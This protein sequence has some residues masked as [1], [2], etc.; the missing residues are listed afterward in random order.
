MVDHLLQLGGKLLTG[1]VS[2]QQ[3]KVQQLQTSQ[4]PQVCKT[5]QLVETPDLQSVE[6]LIHLFTFTFFHVK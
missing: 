6:S 1:I 3:G 5:L 2:Q 4:K